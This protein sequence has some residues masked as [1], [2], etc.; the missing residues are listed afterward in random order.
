MRCA[1]CSRSAL[2]YAPFKC[3]AVR[4]RLALLSRDHPGIAALMMMWQC[5]LSLVD[6][7][8]CLPC[9]P[10][11]ECVPCCFA[12]PVCHACLRHGCIMAVKPTEALHKLPGQP[13]GNL[14]IAV[15]SGATSTRSAH[16]T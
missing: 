12:H 1:K 16:R 8:P 3:T 10:R 13:C 4:V 15:L 7:R 11:L 14:P 2:G 9:L 5:S 6:S